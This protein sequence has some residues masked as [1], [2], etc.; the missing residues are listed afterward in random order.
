MARD[1]D[2]AALE[3]L[4]NERGSELMGAAIAL[5][6]SRQDGEDLL[7]A[8]LE[9]VLR[10]P[11]RVDGDVE[12][13]LRRV[14]YNL[15][16]DGWRRR[17]TWKQKLLP[18]LRAETAT[19][20]DPDPTRDVDL[21]DALVRMLGQLPPRQ[22]AVVVLRYWEQRTETETAAL[23]GCSE[24]T[25]KSAASRGLQHLRELAADENAPASPAA[26]P[27]EDIALTENNS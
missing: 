17:G 13:Y 5:A 21:R 11:R 15:A 8:A 22:R 16:A 2:G 18:V 7:Q 6:G 14:L 3:Q 10:K 25:V 20:A 24:G 27:A 1:R 12:G 9:R 23:L 4:L 26:S 19:A